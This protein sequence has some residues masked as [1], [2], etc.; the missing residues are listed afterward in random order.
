MQLIVKRF[1]VEATKESLTG[2]QTSVG[3]SVGP[4]VTHTIELS[5]NVAKSRPATFAKAT[6]EMNVSFTF[7]LT[8]YTTQQASCNNLL[9][10]FHTVW[11]S[12]KTHSY[13]RAKVK[14]LISARC[15][16][17]HMGGEQGV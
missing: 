6:M 10:G 12:I 2:E 8:D 15:V 16:C 4:A 17:G 14:T 7:L 9:I 11:K 3:Q 13:L 5:N 1:I